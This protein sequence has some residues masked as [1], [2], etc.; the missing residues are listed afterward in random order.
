MLVRRVESYIAL[1]RSCGFSFQSSAILLRSFANY[2]E[3]KG[4]QLVNAQIAIDW[5]G[6]APSVHTRA[7]RL[8]DVIRFARYL[9]AEDSRHQLPKPVFGSEQRPRPVPYISPKKRSNA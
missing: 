9:R 4:Q 5:A 3:A 7:R 8:G 1:R 6:S 2:S